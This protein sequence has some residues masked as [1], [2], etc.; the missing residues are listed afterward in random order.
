[1]RRNLGLK[2]VTISSFGGSYTCNR[3]SS[4]PSSLETYIKRI[5][6]AIERY[7]NR[8]GCR[9][10][11]HFLWKFLQFCR[12]L[13]VKDVPTAQFLELKGQI[14]QNFSRK[15]QLIYQREILRL[16]RQL[17]VILAVD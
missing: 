8:F 10:P 1:M 15:A 7:Q 2:F 3:K 6:E 13:A 5:F 17:I 12:V 4:T 14:S 11:V 16:V 9:V